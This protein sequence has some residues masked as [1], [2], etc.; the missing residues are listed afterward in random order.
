MVPKL[1]AIFVARVERAFLVYYNTIYYLR[2]VHSATFS[3]WLLSSVCFNVIPSSE[4]LSL[5]SQS[6]TKLQICWNNFGIPSKMGSLY[7]CEGRCPEAP[8][9]FLFPYAPD[10]HILKYF[11]WEHEKTVIIKLK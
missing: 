9:N 5:I 3:L 7:Y 2:I 4:Y 8:M 10:F 1:Q 6:V 11:L